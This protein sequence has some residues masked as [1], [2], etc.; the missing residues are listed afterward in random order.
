MNTPEHLVF[1]SMGI[2]S[3]GD[4]DILRVR[5]QIKLTLVR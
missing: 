1:L 4:F 5:L 2:S 3:H